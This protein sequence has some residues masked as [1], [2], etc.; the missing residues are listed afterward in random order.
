VVVCTSRERF[1][2]EVRGFFVTFGR[3]SCHLSF[4][5]DRA[6]FSWSKP[7]SL[8]PLRFDQAECSL[9]RTEIAHF[10][11]RRFRGTDEVVSDLVL[12]APD[13]TERR[14]GFGFPPR[15][16]FGP[17]V[18][19]LLQWAHEVWFTDGALYRRA[20]TEI[21]RP[22]LSVLRRDGHVERLVG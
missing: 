5:L 3:A 21:E 2:I 16:P 18:A 6:V 9:P 10:A 8:G 20:G 12:V 19:A 14:A 7:A 22:V 17:P 13:R 11:W 4:Q 1:A 15:H